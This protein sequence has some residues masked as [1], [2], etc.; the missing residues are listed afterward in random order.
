MA[1]HGKS[2]AASRRRGFV[3]HSYD[4]TRPKDVTVD[5]RELLAER[6]EEKRTHLRSVGPQ[7]PEPIV[8]RD[9]GTDPE[10]EALLADSVG[11]AL[12]VRSSGAQS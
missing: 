4:E 9:S 8:S 10:Q 3:R 7:M 1:F 12:L 6:F 5:E 11:L 2:A